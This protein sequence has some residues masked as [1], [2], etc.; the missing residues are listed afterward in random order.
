[1]KKITICLMAVLALTAMV[2]SLALAENCPPKKTAATQGCPKTCPQAADAKGCG[3]MADSLDKCCMEAALS[4]KGC[5]GKTA[6]QVKEAFNSCPH[7]QTAKAEMHPC[8]V[9]SLDD[10]KGCCGKDAEALKANFEKKVKDALMA[11]SIMKT[12][13]DT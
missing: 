2:S 3:D 5:C 8:C 11:K 13:A 10:S 1:M 9:E 4:A 6:E 7:V 12:Q